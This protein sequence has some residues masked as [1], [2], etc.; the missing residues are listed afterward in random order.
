MKKFLLCLMFT[1]PFAAF[2]ES[3][4]DPCYPEIQKELRKKQ[5]PTELITLEEV[6][7]EGSSSVAYQAYALI[8]DRNDPKVLPIHSMW[9]VVI[10]R[11]ND[12]CKVLDL[13]FLYQI[14]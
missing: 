10:E 4:Q 7:S 13:E 3:S 2:A 12:Q 1:L 5:G 6:Q 8:E 9:L 11:D 14:K